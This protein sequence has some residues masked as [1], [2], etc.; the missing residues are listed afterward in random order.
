MNKTKN[1]LQQIYCLNFLII[2]LFFLLKVK[3]YHRWNVLIFI[4]KLLSPDK[5]K[6]EKQWLKEDG[7][8]DTNLSVGKSARKEKII[9]KWPKKK[10]KKEEEIKFC[11]DIY[12]HTW[13]NR[14]LYRCSGK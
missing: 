7:I 8:T 11:I 1:I 6:S 2:G 3:M 14:N 13:S 10:K 4:Q 9:Q 12:T 5:Y